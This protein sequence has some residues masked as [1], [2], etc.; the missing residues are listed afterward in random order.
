MNRNTFEELLDALQ[1]DL[2]FADESLFPL[3]AVVEVAKT[4]AA[5]RQEAFRDCALA[6]SESLVLLLALDITVAAAGLAIKRL[7]HDERGAVGGVREDVVDIWGRAQA[8]RCLWYDV[9]VG[10][11]KGEGLHQSKETLVRLAS[12]AVGVSKRLGCLV[13][14]YVEFTSQIDSMVFPK[15]F[16][17]PSS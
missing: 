9:I 11:E 8:A 7:A 5:P 2:T 6:T 14:Q 12:D 17:I 16:E 3:E 4:H 13:A 10:G 1:A 15:S